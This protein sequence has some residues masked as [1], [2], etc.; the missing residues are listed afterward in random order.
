MA[1]ISSLAVYALFA[2]DLRSALGIVPNPF[3]GV[4]VGFCSAIDFADIDNDGDLDAFLGKEFG[5]ILYY[6]NVGSSTNPVFQERIGSLNPLDFVDVVGISVPRLVDIDN[7]GDFDV[8][9][10][11]QDGSIFYFENVGTPT[12]PSFVERTG[13]SNPLNGNVIGGAVTGDF[14]PE[15]ADLDNDGDLDAF[16]GDS[17]GTIVFYRNIDSSGGKT[18]PQFTLAP[19][20]ENPFDGIDVGLVA[21]PAIGDFDGDGDMDCVVGEE[22]GSLLYFENTGTVD[23]AVFTELTGELNPFVDFTSQARSLPDFVDIDA[24]GDLDLFV[25][26]FF[27]TILFIRGGDPGLA[28]VYVEFGASSNGN[29]TIGDPFDN[30][31][32]GIACVATNGTIHIDPGTSIEVFTGAN[33]IAAP[34]TLTNFDPGG[35]T[36]RI[37]ATSVPL[38]DLYVDFNAS[39]NG[40]GTI[41]APF[42]NLTDAIEAAAADATIHIEPGVSPEVFTDGNF[43]DVPMILTNYNPPG[44]TV[45]IGV[46]GSERSGGFVSRSGK[47]RSRR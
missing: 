38:L 8:F 18:S 21:A 16:I 4:D 6:E 20:A 34:M 23:N 12:V 45:R 43:I 17:D 40:D 29:G 19:A 14:R 31:A 25:G 1:A 5:L 37:G 27:G 13:P 11:D 42:D 46:I 15:F 7:D 2:S 26:E 47:A 3:E 36:V 24:D 9:V 30:L 28:D 39:S 22:F 41:G 33:V 35:G 32:D 44:G 10:G